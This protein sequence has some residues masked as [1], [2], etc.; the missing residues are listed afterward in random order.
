VRLSA[1]GAAAVATIRKVTL[2]G[3]SNTGASATGL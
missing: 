1:S 3:S 2:S